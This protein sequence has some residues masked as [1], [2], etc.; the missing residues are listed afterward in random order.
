MLPF[1]YLL[2]AMNPE[3]FVHLD[4]ASNKKSAEDC[5]API[6]S[7]QKM[8][9]GYL[10]THTNPAFS[11]I[12]QSDPQHYLHYL[13][14]AQKLHVATLLTMIECNEPN[15]NYLIACRY[16]GDHQST[17]RLIQLLGFIPN[18]SKEKK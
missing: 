18:L 1:F 9:V 3:E 13:Y 15:T 2:Q 5:A 16:Y 7:H 8:I 4:L 6:Y 10:S 11:P 12:T 14:D 17:E